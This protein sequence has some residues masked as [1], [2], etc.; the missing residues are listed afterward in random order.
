MSRTCSVVNVLLSWLNLALDLFGEMVVAILAEESLLLTKMEFGNVRKV[1]T[2][3]SADKQKR[4]SYVF[5][6]LK[7][8]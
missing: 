1:E 2:W 5:R 3:S 4:H 7:G 8:C 6:L